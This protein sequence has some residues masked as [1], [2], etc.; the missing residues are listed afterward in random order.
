MKQIISTALLEELIE[1]LPDPDTYEGD[2]CDI[3]QPKPDLIA[4]MVNSGISKEKE[5]AL[6]KL[7]FYKF[8]VL[9]GKGPNKLYMQ[10]WAFH[11]SIFVDSNLILF[12][13][14]ENGRKQVQ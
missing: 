14:T 5:K 8:P 6:V 9:I 4:A 12:E 11:G 1:F 10:R 13:S 2:F 3:V 7:R